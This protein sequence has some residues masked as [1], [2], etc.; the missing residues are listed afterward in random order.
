MESTCGLTK[1]S[2]FPSSRKVLSQTSPASP[3]K[4]SEALPRHASCLCPS[5]RTYIENKEGVGTGVELCQLVP[6]L[7]HEVAVTW[8][9]CRTGGID[10]GD[11][12]GAPCPVFPVQ[13]QQ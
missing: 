12:K 5:R 13:N 7:V 1:F 11:G 6:D 8:V 2:H 9:A 3:S 10:R 4:S